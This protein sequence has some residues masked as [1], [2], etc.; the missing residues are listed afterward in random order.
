MDVFLSEIREGQWSFQGN[1]ACIDE[2][3]SLPK[4]LCSY[5]SL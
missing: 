4:A 1:G 2:M 3:K 5:W